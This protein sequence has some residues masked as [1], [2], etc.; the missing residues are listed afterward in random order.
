LPGKEAK[1]RSRVHL[2]KGESIDCSH[3]A[4]WTF[5]RVLRGKAEIEIE[6]HE[7]KIRK[8]DL[9]RSE[10]TDNTED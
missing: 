8:V 1:H 9:E 10:T 4:R 2:S 7:C 5:I 3:P 6:E